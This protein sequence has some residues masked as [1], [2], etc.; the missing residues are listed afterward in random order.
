MIVAT[1]MQMQVEDSDELYEIVNGARVVKSLTAYES[2]IASE[3]AGFVHA[4]V[5][6]NHLGRATIEGLFD[7]S[8]VNNIRRPDVAFVSFDRWPRTRGIPRTNAWA[9]V[10]DLAVEVVSPNDGVRDVL[11]KVAEYF[12][13]GVRLVWLVIPGQDLVYCYTSPTA[14]R[15]LSRGDDLTGEPVLP[16]FRLPLADLFPPPDAPTTA[17]ATP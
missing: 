17:D 5:R 3:L 2:F 11:D 12:H 8:N 1:T 6:A 7:L 4:Y 16:G 14:V 15:I 10:P 9:V 13:A